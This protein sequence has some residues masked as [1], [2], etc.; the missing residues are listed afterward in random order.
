M[1]I[2]LLQIAPLSVND[3][4]L[5][6]YLQSC[7]KQ[8]VQI[9]AF[10]EYIFSPFCR[11]IDKK[12]KLFP[13]DCEKNILRLQK[14]SLRHKI[15]IVAPVIICDK[16]KIYKVITLIQ[17]ESVKFYH[18]QRLIAY[19]HWNE[20][21]CFDNTLSKHIKTPLI[22]EKDGLKIAVVAGFEI[23]F[24]EIWLK[25]KMENVD[26]VI[27]PCSNTFNSK[28][29]WRAL[30]QARAFVNSMV[31]LRINRIGTL[32]Y[33]NVDWDFYGDSCFINADGEIEDSLDE[34]EGVMIVELHS[35][36]IKAIQKEWGFR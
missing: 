23:H 1:N 13:K 25:L 31:I 4:R 18:Q 16:N 10:G 21:K 15:D 6:K 7:K 36:Q 8:K 35:E 32:H 3:A 5:N 28:Q 9:A 11:D 19:Q 24:D 12:S 34:K 33:D 22:F 30:S 20:K 27:M 14:L 17:G 26:I 29:R 2:A